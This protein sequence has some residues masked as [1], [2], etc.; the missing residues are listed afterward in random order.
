MNVG[1][2]Q[3]KFL[4]TWELN[5][6]SWVLKFYYFWYPWTDRR[7]IADLKFCRVA[8]SC[9][10]SPLMIVVWVWYGPGLILVRPV[11]NYIA[12]ALDARDERKKQRRREERAEEGRVSDEAYEAAMKLYKVGRY[13]DYR[14]AIELW[15]QGEYAK[16]IKIGS[17]EHKMAEAS[18]PTKGEEK[19]AK[20][21]ERR[22]ANA[23]SR[24]EAKAKAAHVA[25]TIE[26][27]AQKVTMHVQS[28]ARVVGAPI[29]KIRD[30]MKRHPLIGHSIRIVVIGAPALAVLGAVIYGFVWLFNLL[31]N[32]WSWPDFDYAMIA[33]GSVVIVLIVVFSVIWVLDHTDIRGVLNR[34]G[35]KYSESQNRGRVA[36]ALDRFVQSAAKILRSALERVVSFF[37]AIGHGGMAVGKFFANVGRFFATGYYSLKYHTCPKIVVVKKGETA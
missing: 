25:E 24:I 1:A 28:A 19:A 15:G 9:I 13:D 27:T 5:E 17:A 16:A 14:L 31:G 30:A 35:E 32:N 29:R 10:C 20:K 7:N 22:K 6:N 4:H 34:F 33:L 36:T 11:R 2:D 37:V 23:Q 8:W 3:S 26:V 12:A 18:L 21:E